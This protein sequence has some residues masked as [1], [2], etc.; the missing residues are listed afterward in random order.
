V[1]ILLL[2]VIVVA[3]PGPTLA[4]L[5]TLFGAALILAGVAAV[6]QG[7]RMRGS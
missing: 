3:W 6:A 5:T 1:L 4:L 7:L 2:G